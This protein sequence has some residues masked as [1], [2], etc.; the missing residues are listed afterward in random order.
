MGRR[1]AISANLAVGVHDDGVEE[2]L[3]RRLLVRQEL[4]VADR[5]DVHLAVPLAEGVVLAVAD[6]VD[7]LV[8]ELLG[9]HVPHTRARV[10]EPHLDDVDLVL[11]DVLDVEDAVTGPGG[12]T[13][14]VWVEWQRARNRGSCRTWGASGAHEG[15]AEPGEQSALRQV[16]GAVTTCRTGA[17][18][19]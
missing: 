5:Q 19:T 11:V 3:L 4:D 13:P 7:E 9:A 16:E 18:L 12:R 15:P 1:S 10:R 14:R 6:G 2:L 17:L 8:G